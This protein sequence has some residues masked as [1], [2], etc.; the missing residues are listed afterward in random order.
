MTDL[1]KQRDRMDIVRSLL[2]AVTPL[3]DGDTADRMN[4]CFSTTLLVILSAFISGWRSN[5]FIDYYL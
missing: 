1:T 4:Y 5:E 3:P 2:R